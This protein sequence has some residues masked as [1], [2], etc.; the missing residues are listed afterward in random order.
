MKLIP[1]IARAW[2]FIMAPRPF[3]SPQ[4]SCAASGAHEIV[5]NARKFGSS[6]VRSE[7]MM[8]ATAPEPGV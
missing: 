3:L 4:Q 7:G 8:C 1:T 6:G 2:V 5:V